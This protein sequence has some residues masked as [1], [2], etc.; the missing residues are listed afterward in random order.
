M[1][2]SWRRWHGQFPSVA[3]VLDSIIWTEEIAAQWNAF[4]ISLFLKLWGVL[5]ARNIDKFIAI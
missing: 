1:A 2:G 4:I 3:F 5:L